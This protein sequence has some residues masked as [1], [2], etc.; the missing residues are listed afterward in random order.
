MNPLDHPILDRPWVDTCMKSKVRVSLH[1]LKCFV[2]REQKKGPTSFTA[3]IVRPAISITADG[4]NNLRQAPSSENA[5]NR[6]TLG[7][8]RAPACTS[9]NGKDTTAFRKN[10]WMRILRTALHDSCNAVRTMRIH[11][12]FLNAVVSSPFEL[13]NANVIHP[14]YKYHS[15]SQT[16]ARS[17]PIQ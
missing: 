4:F 5:L 7:M 1:N 3:P 13:E 17:H 6:V 10:A 2:I 16:Y 15:M 12:L 11:E 14:S 9:S 8:V